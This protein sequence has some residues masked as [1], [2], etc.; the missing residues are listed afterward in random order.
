MKYEVVES[1][2][3]WIVSREGIELARFDEQ[4]QA[5]DNIAERLRTAETIEGSISLSVRYLARA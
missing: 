5:L 1:P 4:V 3:E 2:E